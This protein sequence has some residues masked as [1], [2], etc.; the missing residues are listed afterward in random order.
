LI[1]EDLDSKIV[2]GLTHASSNALIAEIEVDITIVIASGFAALDVRQA[3]DTAI[4]N[5]LSPQAWDWSP[6]IRRNAIITRISQVPGVSYIQDLDLT[7]PANQYL[8]EIDS[9]GDIQ[10]RYKGV[11]PHATVTVGSV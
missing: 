9:N 10:F 3:V 8:C 7:L 11:L 2:A 1:E 4:S 6:T 5:Y